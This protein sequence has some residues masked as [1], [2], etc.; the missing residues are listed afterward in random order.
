[1]N[2]RIKSIIARMA[3]GAAIPAAAC[4]IAAAYGDTAAD[5]RMDDAAS[6]VRDA[7]NS[8]LNARQPVR[9]AGLGTDFMKFLGTTYDNT[10]VI[11]TRSGEVRISPN[12][13]EGDL[14]EWFVAQRSLPA[15][16]QK[17]LTETQHRQL[18]DEIYAPTNRAAS[19]AV[20][21]Q[22]YGVRLNEYLD[23]SERRKTDK[24]ACAAQVG[25]IAPETWI[26]Y[27][28]WGGYN[29]GGFGST[30]QTWWTKDLRHDDGEPGKYV[31]YIPDAQSRYEKLKS[32]LQSNYADV[33]LAN[34]DDTA[35]SVRA[36][37]RFLE[38]LR[39]LEVSGDVKRS[40]NYT[41]VVRFRDGHTMVVP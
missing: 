4:T 19:L 20:L 8:A 3:L 32:M 39:P 27:Q 37:N 5:L 25:F 41:G 12:G 28:K 34:L 30:Y 24:W 6:I 33:D 16:E 1:M 21:V 18:V 10:I 38:A 23:C 31:D 22:S 15:V 17:S 9:V 14:G 11:K 13:I 29:W 35:D 2:S 36:L 7:R 26:V 40:E